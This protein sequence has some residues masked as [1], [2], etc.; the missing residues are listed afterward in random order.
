MEILLS[1]LMLFCFAFLGYI[2][3]PFPEMFARI[4]EGA[5]QKAIREENKKEQNEKRKLAY[6]YLVIC[7][8]KKHPFINFYLSEDIKEY[9][10]TETIVQELSRQFIKK[11]FT[12]EEQEIITWENEHLNRKTQDG[13]MPIDWNFRRKIVFN[14]DEQICRRCGQFLTITTAH[15]H[16]IVRR[17]DGG[18]HSTNNLITLCK[19]CHSLQDGHE[20]MYT[21]G[22]YYISSTKTIHT[23]KC[24]Y[25]R[26]SKLIKTT[27]PRLLGE[28]Y[29]SCKRCK[30]EKM[31][32]EM[33][34][35]YSYYIIKD[36]ENLYYQILKQI[37]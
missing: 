13:K 24:G 21:I 10:N 1:W 26:K 7:L 31:H 29:H 14:R 6:N 22:H 15:I 9:Y 16:H 28:G 17:S 3:S 18:H 33:K 30:P 19:D 12:I 2:I 37:K 36:I 34:N 8:N 11:E 23:D 5:K 25:K 35:N 32:N 4:K 20:I 27:L